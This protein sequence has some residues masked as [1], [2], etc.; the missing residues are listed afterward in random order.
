MSLIHKF[1]IPFLKK[2]HVYKLMKLEEYQ[3]SNLKGVTIL[4]IIIII[5]LAMIYLIF[6]IALSWFLADFILN[7]IGWTVD[8]RFYLM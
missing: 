5:P 6:F 3:I 2:T 4:K 7:Y 8:M 1:M